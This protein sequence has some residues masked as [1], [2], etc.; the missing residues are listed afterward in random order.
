MVTV[1]LKGAGCFVTKEAEKISLEGGIRSVLPPVS[2]TAVGSVL[3][4]ADTIALIG[5]GY[6]TYD[7][8][9][10]YSINQN[11]YVTAVSFIWLVSLALMN[12]AGLYRYEVAFRPLGHIH[13][14]VIAIGTAFLFLLAA[15]FSIKM[16]ESL[17]RLW[18][19]WFALL[20]IA[21][22]LVLRLAISFGMARVL[23]LRG[24]KRNLAVVGVGAISQRLVA[25]LG[26][27]NDF[28]V[29]VKYVYS[30]GTL[31]PSQSTADAA[32]TGDFTKLVEHAR[33]GM[34]DDIVIALP[35]GE[36]DRIMDIVSKL[37]E[38]PIN[39]YIVCDLVG[40]RTS[41]RKPP[42]HFGDLPVMQIIGKPMSGWDAIIK[43]CEDYLLALIAAVVVSPFL[44]IVA[45]LIKLDSPGPIIF[46]QKRL[47]FNNQV[48]GVYK[49]RTMQHRPV[50]TSVT[51]Q[52]KV[53]DHRV[54][55][56]GKFLRRWS[57][58]E[59]PQIFNVLNGTMSIVGPRPHALDHN[60]DFAQRMEGYFARHRVKPGITGLAQ[61]RGYRG[62]TDTAEKLEGRVRNDIFYAENWSLSLD[63][64]I[65]LRTVAV[66]LIG[67]NAY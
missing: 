51:E 15:A 65:I 55:R 31:G 6:F 10:V 53:G 54:T 62:E 42:S 44:L 63:I 11:I 20:A 50:Q 26:S 60:R 57:I 32:I 22:V 19:L 3:C 49:F 38:L 67:K 41:F 28:P 37:R 25:L 47:G 46:K 56:I 40:F 27:E 4:L 24:S 23:K 1:G 52:A 17:S 35:W 48:F 30:D 34:I 29:Q 18:L 13:T 9:I 36:D 5:A 8:L 59:L 64:W 66:C 45:I 14:A 58:D 43:L 21:S 39:V 33:A 7:R 2:A 12:Y 16:S 61:V